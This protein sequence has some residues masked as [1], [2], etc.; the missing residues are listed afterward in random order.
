VRE[1]DKTDPAALLEALRQ[2]ER[3]GDYEEALEALADLVDCGQWRTVGETA[4]RWHEQAMNGNGEPRARVFFDSK[5]AACAANAFRLLAPVANVGF[6][7]ECGQSAQHWRSALRCG[8]CGELWVVHVRVPN[9]LPRYVEALQLWRPDGWW[10]WLVKSVG[11][12]EWYRVMSGHQAAVDYR[13]IQLFAR[14]GGPTVIGVRGSV[15]SGPTCPPLPEVP[16]E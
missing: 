13:P 8:G 9:P 14:D 6:C 10:E 5:M 3:R 7:N 1:H 16:M 15:E 2:A 4:E 11:P 12:P